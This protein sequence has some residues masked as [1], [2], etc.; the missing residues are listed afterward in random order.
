VAQQHL[1]TTQIL[2]EI[3]ADGFDA[4][5]YPGGHGPLWDLSE[6]SDS[7]ALI[8]TFNATDRPIGAVCHDRSTRHWFH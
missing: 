7:K 8:E 4:I 3:T 6:D 5:F 2:S 1:A